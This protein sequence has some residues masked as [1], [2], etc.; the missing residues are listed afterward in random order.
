MKSQERKNTVFG[1]LLKKNIKKLCF[2]INFFAII[3]TMREY[4]DPS[5]HFVYRSSDFYSAPDPLKGRFYQFDN[6]RLNDAP[7]FTKCCILH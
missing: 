7:R 3:S 2:N 4:I 6:V 1:K 5:S